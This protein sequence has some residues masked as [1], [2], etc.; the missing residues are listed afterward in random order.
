MRL[1]D[2]TVPL[3]VPMLLLA[4]AAWIPQTADSDG[5]LSFH[6][7]VEAW[8]H[9]A[10]TDPG[11]ELVCE[12]RAGEGFVSLLRSQEQGAWIVVF[13]SLPLTTAESVRLR[14]PDPP[15]VGVEEVSDWAY[16]FDRNGD[17]AIDY[18]AYHVGPLPIKAEDFPDDYPEQYGDPREAWRLPVTRE[19][20]D[21]YFDHVTLVFLH[22]ADDDHDGGIDGLVHEV[23]DPNRH[24]VE[25]WVA[26]RRD[27]AGRIEAWYFKENIAIREG[28]PEAEDRSYR[29]H[30]LSNDD[31]YLDES[32]FEYWTKVLVHVN[33]A[34]AQCSVD[35]RP[36][37]G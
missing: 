32:D 10:R 21:Y 23:L 2:P 13:S 3:L 36:R 29:I 17:G 20:L 18:L 14:F 8:A 15:P 6:P 27:P 12:R 34:V 33:D 31:E 11:L 26:A 19:Q 37:T 5:L 24:W 28:L 4:V 22:A 35:A 30:S 1:V 16:V 9:H 25:R 7:R